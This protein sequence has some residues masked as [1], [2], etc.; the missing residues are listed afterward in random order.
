MRRVTMKCFLASLVVAALVEA[1]G[2]ES[3]EQTETGSGGGDQAT[4]GSPNAAASG[5]GGSGGTS[6]TG[7]IGTTGGASSTGGRAVGGSETSGAATGGSGTGGNS[8]GVGGGNAG[9]SAAP[10]GGSDTGGQNT[11]I[12]GDSLG[13]AS[14]TGGGSS[15]GG[16]GGSAPIGGAGT[17]GGA[18]T[19]GSTSGG[20]A[21]TGGST[22]GGGAE[23]GGALAGCTPGKLDETA[24]CNTPEARTGVPGA[25]VDC[26][27]ELDGPWGSVYATIA[28]QQYFLQVN[29]W[30]SKSPQTM[31]H[32]GDYFFRMTVQQASTGTHG[33]GAPTGYPSMF[34]GSNSGH[35]T[36]NSN[37]PKAISEIKSVRTT[38]IWNDN[39][40]L[41]DTETNI[42]NAAYDVWFNQ[43]VSE[44][45]SSGPTGGYLMVWPYDPPNAEPIGGAPASTAVS[46]D[47]VDGTWDIWIGLNGT[48]PCISYVRTETTL[49]LSF[50]LKHFID[51]ATTRQGGIDPS[52]A[53]TNV[54]TGFEIWQGAQGVETTAF[55]AV[56]E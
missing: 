4:G 27:G 39:G 35:T 48:R 34:I 28:G 11:G 21:E 52:W 10:S 12:G 6:S 46:I 53:L 8:V 9:R 20:G 40:T 44:S 19:G 47:G 17:G 31:A 50:D 32:G 56:V 29:E 36:A 3:K 30:G 26:V 38:W 7:G 16:A 55:C 13:G 37:L 41:G 54:F 2:S 5:A 22:S 23:T 14:A 24:T 51:D 15:Q 1:C 43:N 18:E 25:A 49:E 45:T 33:T 42:F